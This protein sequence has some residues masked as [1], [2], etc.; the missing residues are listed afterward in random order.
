MNQIWISVLTT[1]CTVIASLAA[2]LIFNKLTGLPKTIKDQKLKEKKE[3]DQLNERLD[4]IE[5]RLSTVEEAISHYP[6]YRN[7]SIQMQQQLQNSDAAIVDLCRQIKD[8][9]TANREILN[10]RLSS[11]ENREKNSLRAKILNEYRLYTDD[12]KNP[13][14]AWSEMEH[15]S[16]FKL[17]E[18][19]ESLGGNDYV[20][21]TILPAMN[22]LDVIP[23][24][25]LEALK[26]L[27]SSRNVC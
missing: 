19:Y 17:V 2:T 7:Q 11:L 27:Y 16:F 5:T 21:G 14:Q 4:T 25:D 6:E 13:M 8:E 1:I 20:H 18:D 9:V 23:M 24:T 26:K 10:S 3:K 12:I 22:E 15:H